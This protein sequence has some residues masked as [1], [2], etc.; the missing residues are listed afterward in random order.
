M[1][2]V[3]SAVA[4]YFPKKVEQV[5]S[6]EE[7]SDAMARSGYVCAGQPRFRSPFV[8]PRGGA[9]RRVSVG[10]GVHGA[11]CGASR[12]QHDV[13]LQ[14]DFMARAHRDYG[15]ERLGRHANRQA[16]R[17]SVTT[18]RC[19]RPASN[20]TVSASWTPGWPMMSTCGLAQDDPR[21]QC[22]R[23]WRPRAWP[24]NGKSTARARPRTH[25]VSTM[26]LAIRSRV[27]TAKPRRC[28]RVAAG[29]GV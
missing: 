14:Q 9:R 23:G 16:T 1:G 21:G 18:G 17:R 29:R 13:L 6:V 3:I 19:L 5:I 25:R 27:W 4:F 7:A 8:R 12:R 28:G 20:V 26:R 24:E 2:C 10:L 22:G 11:R 15:R